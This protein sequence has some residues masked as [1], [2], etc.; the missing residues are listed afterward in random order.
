MISLLITIALQYTQTK[1]TNL[2][3]KGVCGERGRAGRGGGG[4]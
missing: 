1:I 4:G 2:S 3:H